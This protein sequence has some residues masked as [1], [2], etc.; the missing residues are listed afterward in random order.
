MVVNFID[1]FL[2]MGQHPI[3]LW[4][5]QIVSSL[6]LLSGQ[7]PISRYSMVIFLLGR[8]KCCSCEFLYTEASL[9]GA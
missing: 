9:F 7:E 1:C 6:G 2:A 8:M 4:Q 5:L 3:D